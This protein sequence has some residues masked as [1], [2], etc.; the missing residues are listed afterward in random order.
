V[1]QESLGWARWACRWTDGCSCAGAKSQKTHGVWTVS[2][3]SWSIETGNCCGFRVGDGDRGGPLV[4]S[5][6]LGARSATGCRKERLGHL[7]KGQDPRARCV[8]VGLLAVENVRGA[9]G[10]GRRD[11]GARAAREAQVDQGSLCPQGHGPRCGEPARPSGVAVSTL[12]FAD[13]PRPVG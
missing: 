7:R 9:T 13:E 8:A 10:C 6:E 11:D 12:L 5:A 2:N 3:G 1:V 4:H